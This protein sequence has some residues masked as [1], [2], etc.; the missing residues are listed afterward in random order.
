MAY[1]A[2]LNH[3]TTPAIIQHEDVINLDAVPRLTVKVGYGSLGL[4]GQA[5]LRK[6][7]R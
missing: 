2:A 1:Q 4:R 6:Q 5:G 7:S 3:A